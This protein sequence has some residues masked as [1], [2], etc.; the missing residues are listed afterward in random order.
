MATKPPKLDIWMLSELF[1]ILDKEFVERIQQAGKPFVFKDEDK[2][3]KFIKLISTNKF[4]KVGKVVLIRE[5]LQ[6][7]MDVN[8]EL[9]PH[10][11]TKQKKK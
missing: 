5:R 9:T 8:N 11:P 2:R 1:A 6:Q 4:H 7:M 3:L 10:N